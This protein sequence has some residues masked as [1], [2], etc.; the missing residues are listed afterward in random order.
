M[1]FHPKIWSNPK[2]FGVSGILSVWWTI[3]EKLLNKKSISGG[4]KMLWGSS[5][6]TVMIWQGL[7]HSKSYE[8]C[9]VVLCFALLLFIVSSLW[10][11]VIHLLLLS[12]RAASLTLWQS[13]VCPWSNPEG[14]GLYWPVL[15]YNQR[16]AD[17]LHISWDV[18]YALAWGT[19]ANKIARWTSELWESFLTYSIFFFFNKCQNSCLVNISFDT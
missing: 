9:I 4:F 2:G 1:W 15:N 14:Y 8:I 13:Y 5:H 19:K 17:H 18:I 6:D 12:L 11:P 16:C 10:M 7:T 3:L